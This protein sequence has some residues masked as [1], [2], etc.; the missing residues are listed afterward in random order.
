MCLIIGT[1]TINDNSG[2]VTSGPVLNASPKSVEK[3]FHGSGGGNIGNVINE[4]TGTS[5]T[6]TFDLTGAEQSMAANA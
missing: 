6:N 3:S 4:I 5:S 1:F 2:T